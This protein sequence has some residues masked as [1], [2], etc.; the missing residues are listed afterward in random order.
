MEKVFEIDRPKEPSAISG[1]LKAYF[2]LNPRVSL[3]PCLSNL[4]LSQLASSW[5]VTIGAS[6]ERVLRDV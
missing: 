3:L 1:Q 4:G 2:H 5:L 6:S